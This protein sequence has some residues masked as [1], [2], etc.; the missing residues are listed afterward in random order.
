MAVNKWLQFLKGWRAKHKGVSLRD[1]M[2]KASAE[3]RKSKSSDP[4]KKTQK[5]R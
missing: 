5:K 1:S 4:K 3:Y 2:K